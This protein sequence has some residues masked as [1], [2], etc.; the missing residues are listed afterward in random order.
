MRTLTL[1]SLIALAAAHPAESADELTAKEITTARKIYVAKCAKC[2]RFYEPANYSEP[3]WRTWM[4]KMSEKSK[5][6]E[7][8]ASLLTRYLAAYRAG[9]LSGKPQDKPKSTPSGTAAR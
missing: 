4:E 9:R 2:H 1:C 5:L 6:K 7:E 3:G 8:Q